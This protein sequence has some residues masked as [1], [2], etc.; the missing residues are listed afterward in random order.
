MVH[1]GIIPAMFTRS[2]LT[3]LPAIIMDKYHTINVYPQL[4]NNFIRNGFW[5]GIIPAM[6]NC[7]RLTTLPAMIVGRYHTRNV[8]T[9]SLNSFTR[10]EFG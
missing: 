1:V 8:N 2:H 10:N 7:T 6:L 4:L 3:T 9:H 5:V